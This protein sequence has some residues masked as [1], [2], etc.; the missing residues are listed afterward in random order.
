[1]ALTLLTS[2]H[3]HL[4]FFKHSAGLKLRIKNIDYLVFILPKAL[5]S[6]N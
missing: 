2:R 1:M 5:R 4:A 6:R 3:L